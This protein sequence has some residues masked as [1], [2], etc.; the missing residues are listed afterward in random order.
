MWTAEKRLNI[1][2]KSS[3]F[4]WVKSNAA[5]G[6][7]RVGE[8]DVGSNKLIYRLTHKYVCLNARFSY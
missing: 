1:Y 4:V 6:E 5:A 7:V 2:A 8:L 3:P